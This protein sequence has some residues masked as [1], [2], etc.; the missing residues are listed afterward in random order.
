MFASIQ[1]RCPHGQVPLAGRQFS[2]LPL[3]L[4]FF[5][6]VSVFVLPAFYHLLIN[7]RFQFRSDDFPTPGT[8]FIVQPFCAAEILLPH[9]I[10]NAH[11]RIP[12]IP[13]L[14]FSCEPCVGSFSGQTGFS[15]CSS[16][17]YGRSARCRRG[18]YPHGEPAPAFGLLSRFFAGLHIPALIEITPVHAREVGGVID[19]HRPLALEKLVH[20]QVRLHIDGIA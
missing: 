12:S 17:S 5:L 20:I 19:K 7:N 6:P 11:K 9:R 13:A 4:F 1:S 3:P 15:C 2:G 14:D 10:V 18:R 16:A 8:A